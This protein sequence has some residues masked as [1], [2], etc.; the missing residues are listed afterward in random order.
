MPEFES[1]PPLPVGNKKT[2]A[3]RAAAYF[4]TLFRPWTKAA[5][6]NLSY[7]SWAEWVS[8]LQSTGTVLSLFRLA[9]MTRMS[10]GFAESAE[11]AK[12]N[13]QYRMR[14]CRFWNS[15]IPDGTAPP[16]GPHAPG[17]FENAEDGDA[18]VA[19]VAAEAAAAIEELVRQA[20]CD[21]LHLSKTKRLNLIYC[22]SKGILNHAVLEQLQRVI[23]PQSVQR[24]RA[25]LL[26]ARP[27]TTTT[28]TRSVV[29][30][31][32]RPGDSSSMSLQEPTRNHA[33]TPKKG[34]LSDGTS[35]GALSLV[36]QYEML[37][38]TLLTGF[39]SPLIITS[40]RNKASVITK[41]QWYILAIL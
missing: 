40:Q 29:T 22:I 21:G 13:S 5:L 7:V 2:L 31:G 34:G 14:N 17:A 33:M 37:F 24:L 8:Q 19:A 30:K 20:Q 38:H 10:Q 26:R 11:S 41:C 9:V 36:G 1:P 35:Q 16:P 28:P 15:T 39:S 25:G 6:P 18:D 23:V 3:K 12:I 32:R 27:C 4:V